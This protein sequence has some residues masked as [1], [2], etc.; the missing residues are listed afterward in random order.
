M[1]IDKRRESLLVA[2]VMSKSCFV[3]A[4]E[5]GLLA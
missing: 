5:W 3:P 1:G 2:P 4:K